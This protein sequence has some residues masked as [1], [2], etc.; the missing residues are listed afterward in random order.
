MRKP[1]RKKYDNYFDYFRDT[2]ESD[3]SCLEWKWGNDE[4][5]KLRYNYFYMPVHRFI[6]IIYRGLIPK[7]MLVLHNCFNKRCVNI[8][9]LRLGTHQENTQ[10]NDLGKLCVKDVH[11]IKYLISQ[12]VQQIEIAERFGV[13]RSVISN[14]KGK[15]RWNNVS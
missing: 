12:G 10:D 15:K 5:G 6:W 14:I 4:Y 7:G 11:Q 8:E 13:H 1:K 9:H 2:I 3:N